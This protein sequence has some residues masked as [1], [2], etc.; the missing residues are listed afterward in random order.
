MLLV[1]HK[2]MAAA[3]SATF[4]DPAS[5]YHSGGDITFNYHSRLI[6]G[7]GVLDVKRMDDQS[8]GTSCDSAPC[9]ISGNQSESITLTPFKKSSSKSDLILNYR[10]TGAISPGH[11]DNIELSNESVLNTT[12][13]GTYYIDKLDLKYRATVYLSSGTYWIDTLNMDN[14][15][16]LRLMPGAQ[17]TLYVKHDFEVK[18]RAGLNRYDDADAGNFLLIAHNNAKIHNEVQINGFLYIK[19]RIE[20]DYRARHVGAVN[21]RNILLQNE[22]SITYAP[23]AISKLPVGNLCETPETLPD[24][25][26]HWPFDVCSLTGRADDLPELITGNHGTSSNSPGIKENGRRCQAG[27]FRGNGDIISIPHHPLYADEDFS[28]SFW[29]YTD[30]LSYTHQSPAGG[31]TMLSK[32]VSGFG[33]GGHFSLSV[34]STGNITV[35]QQSGYASYQ[36]QSAPVINEHQWH[37]VVYT[38]GGAGMRLYVDKAMVAFNKSYTDGVIANDALITLAANAG[39]LSGPA[40]NVAQLTDFFRGELDDLRIYDGQL[41]SAQVTLLYDLQAETCITCQS[42]AYLVSHWD[43]DMC[44]LNGQAGDVVEIKN[45]YHG[46]SH[47]GTTLNNTGRFCQ[48]LD[49]N[50]KAFVDVEHQPDFALSAGTIAFWF[51]VDSLSGVASDRMA[52][53]SKDGRQPGSEGYFTSYI[54]GLGK[55]IFHQE[56]STQTDEV[57]SDATLSAGQ[58]HHIAYQWSASGMRYYIDGVFQGSHATAYSWQLNEQPLVFGASGENFAQGYADKA[59]A[60]QYLTGSLDD[61]RLYNGLLSAGE[62]QA[63][64]DA[65]DYTCINCNDTGPTAEYKFEALSWSGAASVEDSSGHSHHGTPLNGVTPELLSSPV[66]CRALNVPYNDDLAK[67]AVDTLVDVNTIGE[68]G[69]ISFWYRSNTSWINGGNR[70]LLDASRGDKYFYL[71]LL[72]NGKL[73]FGLEDSADKYLQYRSNDMS[74]MAGEWVHI[75]LTWDIVS[76]DIHL[77]INGREEFIGGSSTLIQAELGA[78]DTLVIGDNSSAYI[79]GDMTPNS[80]NG[81]FDDVRIY[82]FEQTLGLVRADMRNTTECSSVHHYEVVHPSQALTCDSAD[83]TI[84]A[85]ANGECTELVSHAV[86]VSLPAGDWSESSPLT[87]TGSTSLSLGQAQTG[88]FGISVTGSDATSVAEHGTT[89]SANCSINFVN[90]GLAFYDAL[91]PYQA[92]LPDLVAESDLGRIGLRAVRDNSGVCVAMLTGAQNINLTYDCIDGGTSYSPD[93]CSVPFAGISVSGDGSTTNSGTV[94][95]TFNQN[96]E[97]S[98]SGYH[99]ADA[100]K[101]ALQ[102]SANIAGVVLD[103]GSVQFNSIPAALVLASTAAS[104]QA[105]GADFELAIQAVGASGSVLPG[106][107]PGLLQ[108]SLARL[109]PQ[110]A[111]AGDTRLKISDSLVLTSAINSTWVSTGVGPF[112]NGEWRYSHASSDDVGVYSWDVQDAAYFGNVIDSDSL[113]L[114]RFIPAYFD[115]ALAVT[116]QLAQQ[117]SGR[118]T[119]IGQS[120]EMA[121]GSEPELSVTALNAQGQ[122]TQNYSGTLWQL[123]PGNAALSAVSFADNSQYHGN[124]VT[125]NN[126]HTPIVAEQSDY[127]GQGVILLSGSQFQYAKIATPSAG[128]GNGSAFAGDISMTIGAAF[129]TDN[130]GV[131]YQ[132]AYPGTC[133]S[134][135]IPSIQGSEMRYGRL[136]IENTFGPETESLSAPIVAEYYEQGNWLINKDDS[137]TVLN[138]SQDNGSLSIEN[139]SVGTDE[140]DVSAYLPTVNGY[141]TLVSGKSPAAALSLGPAMNNGVALRGAVRLTLEPAASGAT[142]SQYLN[143]DWDGDGDIDDDDKPA[144]EAFFGIYRGNDRT[145]HMREGF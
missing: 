115:V 132:S 86:N 52:L 100:G 16:N 65:A 18:Y 14:E 1:S 42:N 99:Y 38:T 109:T 107:S 76:Q 142:W 83:I 30:D 135:A 63:L 13:S 101:V 26:G 29:M 27:Q 2:L 6:G 12:A 64:V 67:V 119:Y 10:E 85:C 5:S 102:A 137:C 61:I 50:G 21:A 139:A 81:Y 37:H 20:Y 9:S 62:V 33:A 120:F 36:M 110:S 25:V 144:A 57:V 82:S 123:N 93:Q 121:A 60:S 111:S 8:A 130:D 19:K 71:T 89:C 66:S 94:S 92:S 45:G 138:F 96:G 145:I 129:L 70:Q 114:N 84:K 141:G 103:S 49:F 98:L 68:R 7:D 140:S 48:A 24:P 95:V 126:A 58:W 77:Y 40:Q 28:V 15:T 97:A 127:D 113:A 39:S 17:V 55:L 116:P 3:C 46:T 75:G 74:F 51:K 78:L 34:T 106:Y 105:A 128:A 31:M 122:I 88:A 54:N 22:A 112:T 56:T 11:Y 32:D 91:A 73:A 124:L 44:S 134:F 108:M 143:I 117:C 4:P 72:D 47:T 59:L 87:F 41:S 133:Q 90:A 23:S 118:F 80:A 79:V 125:L 104:P 136:R 53:V 69:T 35:K 43:F 131:C